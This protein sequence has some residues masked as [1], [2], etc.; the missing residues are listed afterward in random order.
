MFRDITIGQ[1]YPGDSII[2]K[3]DPRVKILG[4]IVYIAL[5]FIIDNIWELILPAAMLFILI[6]ISKVP[7]S[8]ILR[9][10]KMLAVLIAFAV[11]F[12][13]LFTEGENVLWKWWAFTIS[14]EGILRAGFFAA[15]LILV[16]LGASMLTYTTTP[17]TLTSGLEK[18]LSPV[19]KLGFPVHE[20]A[21]MMSIALRFIPILTEEINK[22]IKAQLAR[23]ADFESGG[24][25]KK[26][27]GMIP[28][29]IPLFV[30]AFKRA[31]D[32]ATAMEARCYNG[33]SGRTKM[34]PLKY[35]RS[36]II[37]YSVIFAALAFMIFVR[38][39]ADRA[40]IP[41]RVS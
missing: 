27:K 14:R 41:G 32:L 12:N 34:H 8:Y 38:I 3:T 6:R 35:K 16:V 21:M 5:L 9:G 36:D 7:I 17:T 22:I 24:L 29:L 30:Q 18:A 26:A 31:S 2:H 25:I 37:S 28:I 40:G 23:G 10:L 39:A 33:G 4:V 20:L 19:G 13:L 1:Y 11:V 15:R